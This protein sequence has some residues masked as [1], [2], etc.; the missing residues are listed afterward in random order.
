MLVIKVREGFK[1]ENKQKLLVKSDL[2][3]M[4]QILYD[5]A[6][7]E[8]LQVGEFILAEKVPTPLETGK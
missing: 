7:Q 1:N 4:K 5:R 2:H 8:S 6:L 3:A